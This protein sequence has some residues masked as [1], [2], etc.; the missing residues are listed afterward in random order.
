MRRPRFIA[1]QSRHANGPLGRFIA[2]VM[3]RETFA[4]NQRAIEALAIG[5]N[6]HVLDVGCGHGRSLAELA[7]RASRGHVTGVDPSDLMAEIAVNRNRALVKVK[8]IDIVIATATDLPFAGSAFNKVLCVHVIYFWKDLHAGFREIARVLKPGGRLAVVFRSSR[9]ASAV[10]AFP[11]E[12]YTFP[13]LEEVEATLA[14]AGFK[15]EGAAPALSDEGAVRPH[16]I[17]A[18]RLPR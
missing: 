13:Q 9:R 4:D 8:K 16:L 11:P 18:T 7:K 17:V 1:E 10:S 15:V 5:D 3:A 2:F 12:V 6:D 14:A